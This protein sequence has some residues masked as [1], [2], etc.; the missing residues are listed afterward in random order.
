[1][2][3]DKVKKVS[4]RVR[5]IYYDQFVA[6]TKCEELRAL[7]AYWVK[8]LCPYV[9]PELSDHPEVRNAD[10]L[11][12]F[13]LSKIK[14]CNQPKIAVIHTPGQ[15]TLRFR[16]G[17]IWVDVPWRFLGGELSEQGNQ[18]IPTELCIVTKIED[19][20]EV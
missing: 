19:R 11:S 14:P 17:A 8:I 6:G 4:F 16:I 1:M 9:S 12:G 13:V 3:K 7:T 2:T 18:D 15:P 5:R 10:T 20:V